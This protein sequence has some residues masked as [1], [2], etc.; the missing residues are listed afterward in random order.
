MERSENRL[1]KFKRYPEYRD[2]EVEWLGE[3]P[4]HWRIE[5]LKRIASIASGFAPPENFDRSEG[6]YPVYGSNGLIGF[7][8]EFLLSEETLAVGRVGASGQI[9]VIPPRS[10][11]SDNALLLR[12]LNEKA[13][14]S[15]LRYVLETMDLSTQA[16]KNAQPIITGTFLGNQELPLSPELEQLA[17]ATFLD[18]ETARID[19]LIAKKERLIELLQEKRT[20]LI[21][22]AVT[23]GL[24]PAV[25]MKDSGVEWLG[26]IPSHW[27]ISNL[28]WFMNVRS[29]GAIPNTDFDIQQSEDRPFP[30]IG[31]NGVMGYANASN[32]NQTAI[33]IG[34]VGA[35]CG[36]VHL[37]DPPAWVTDNAL[38]VDNIRGYSREFLFLALQGMK[39]NDWASHNAQPLITGGFVK[40]QKAPMPPLGEQ[41]LIWSN[42]NRQMKKIDILVNKI[43]GNIELL[44]EYRTALISAAVTGKIDVRDRV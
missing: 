11:V 9:N 8:D 42:L 25:P 12:D 32:I 17:I 43:E 33:A 14:L 16:T 15:W 29:G 26:E 37:V 30:V 7:C 2:S 35:L 31:G 27:E 5:R 24:D 41:K 21:T 6:K 1:R 28:R 20:A 19:A 18:R 36:N 23:K 40:S 4:A 34:R 10:W 22:H 39:L 44:K 13:L 3:I 38:L